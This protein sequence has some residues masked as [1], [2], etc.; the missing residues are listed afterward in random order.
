MEFDKDNFN[1]YLDN[2]SLDSDYNF[3]NSEC[4]FQENFDNCFDINKN[5][6]IQNFMKIDYDVDYQ[7]MFESPVQ[8]KYI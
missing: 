1:S 2:K 8:S 3:N 6:F 4:N 5:Q 7:R